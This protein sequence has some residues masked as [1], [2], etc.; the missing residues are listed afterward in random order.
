MSKNL[1]FAFTCL[2]K[3]SVCTTDWKGYQNVKNMKELGGKEIIFRRREN[4]ARKV[5]K[6]RRATKC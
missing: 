4:G 2:A 5:E 3:N 6:A 1:S